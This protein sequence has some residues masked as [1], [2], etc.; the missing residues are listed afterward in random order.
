MARTITTLF[1]LALLTGSSGQAATWQDLA[2]R[3]GC[4]NQVHASEQA[5]GT[6]YILEF[7][8][9]GQKLGTQE[10][11]FTITLVRTSQTEAEAN[12]HVEQVTKSIAEIASRSGAKVIEFTPYKGNHG[13]AAYFEFMLQGE[14]NVGVIQRTGPGIIAV[15]QLAT[16]Q[17]RT[18]TNADRAAVKA[19]LGIK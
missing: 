4:P 12:Q 9:Q 18:P 11:M 17:G 14:Y 6:Q 8:P 5:G 19:M 10:R 16:F 7:V 3:V 1:A 2:A 15:Q 13:S